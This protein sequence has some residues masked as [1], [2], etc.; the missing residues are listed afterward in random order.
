MFKKTV[1]KCEEKLESA[2]FNSLT[3]AEELRMT[4]VAIP[5]ISSAL[6]CEIQSSNVVIDDNQAANGNGMLPTDPVLNKIDRRET[7]PPHISSS[8]GDMHSLGMEQSKQEV[9]K[10]VNKI[11][12]GSDVNV[13]AVEAVG[14]TTIRDITGRSVFAYILTRK[15]RAKA[16]GNR[17]AVKIASD[18]AFYP[19]FLFQRFLVVSKSGDPSLEVVLSLE[20]SSNPAA[21]FETKKIL[22]R[23][24]NLRAEMNC[25][26]ES[27]A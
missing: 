4:S 17:L 23:S 14:K 7:T 24:G 5:S 8:G 20:L 26:H 27:D 18:R 13:H 19:A 3:K 12:A 9:L 2:I 11:V 21:F 15:Y 16:L 22:Y 10:H 25:I 1:I 6:S